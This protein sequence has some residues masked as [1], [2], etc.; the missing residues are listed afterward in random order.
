MHFVWSTV[1]NPTLHVARTINKKDCTCSASNYNSSYPTNQNG[2]VSIP[3]I[4]SDFSLTMVFTRLVE[5][6]G[7][8]KYLAQEALEPSVVCNKTA[9]ESNSSYS[10]FWLS[11]MAWTFFPNNATFVGEVENEDNITT[12]F[13]I[14]VSAVIKVVY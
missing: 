8:E 9:F 11:D 10:D 4:E 1:E 2:T 7:T 14:R 5:F 3:G 12:R 6:N 13:S